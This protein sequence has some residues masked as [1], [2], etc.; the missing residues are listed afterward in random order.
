[1]IPKTPETPGA[2]RVRLTHLRDRKTVLDE[3]IRSLERY[4]VYQLPPPKP[5]RGSVAKNRGDRLLAGA[6]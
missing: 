6:A 1:M 3:L 2:I 4:A 5:Q